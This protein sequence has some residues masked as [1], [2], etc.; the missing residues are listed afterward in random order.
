MKGVAPVE[1]ADKPS[2]MR[3]PFNIRMGMALWN[4]A[5]L[6][7]QVFVPDAGKDALWNRGAYIVEGLGHCGTCHHAA[8]LRHAGKGVERRPHELSRRLDA[9]G[10]ARHRLA[11][12]DR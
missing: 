3:F 5:F 4:L 7:K 11:Q 6:D 12:T 9:R 10:L 2:E 1:Q 8:R